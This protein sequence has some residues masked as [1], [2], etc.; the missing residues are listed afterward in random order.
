MTTRQAEILSFLC[1]FRARHQRPPT[2]SDIAVRFGI[3][4]FAVQGHLKALAAKGA[5]QRE[6]GRHRAVGV[7]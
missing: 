3:N 6:S 1:A 5:I 2:I 4:R 7:T